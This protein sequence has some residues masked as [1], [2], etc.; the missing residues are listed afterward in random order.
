V[1]KGVDAQDLA[2][3][4]LRILSR[5]GVAGVAGG[6]EEH[7]VRID[8]ERAGVSGRSPR[9]ARQHRFGDVAGGDPDHPVVDGSGDIGVDQ[10]IF[11]IAGG[12]RETGEAAISGRVDR[13]R[14]YLLVRSVALNLQDSAGGAFSDQTHRRGARQYDQRGDR[15]QAGRD[16]LRVRIRA[17]LWWARRWTAVWA[18]AGRAGSLRD[19]QP[20]SSF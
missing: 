4:R 5:R 17:A 14:G 19:F 20:R 13:Q 6:D 11:G 1:A 10:L 15:F 12:Q 7:S 2:G 16:D 18:R 8:R 9:D 3:E